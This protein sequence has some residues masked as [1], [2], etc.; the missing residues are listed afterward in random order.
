MWC[1]YGRLGDYMWICFLHW[2]S[3]FSFPWRCSIRPW[4]LS[5]KIC[6]TFCITANVY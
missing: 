5:L 1:G 2:S 3:G 6:W 4:K